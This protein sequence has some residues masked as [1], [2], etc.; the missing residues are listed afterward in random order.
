ML[1]RIEIEPEEGSANASIIWLH[2]LGASGDDFAPIVPQLKLDE[3]IYARFIFPHAP[4]RAI[5]F[6][7]GLEMPAWYDF[8]INGIERE[9]NPD[10]LLEI[11]Q[12][13]CEL[14]QLEI[15]RGVKSDRIV[16]AGFSQGGAIAYDVAFCCEKPLAGLMAMSTY[17]A[18]FS[19]LEHAIQ[20]ANFPVHIFHGTQDQV[21][22]LSLGE[23]AK[24]ALERK[25]W[26]PEYSLY[27][28]DHSVCLAQIRDISRF[29]NRVL[30]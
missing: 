6:N 17:I 30:A 13:V 12:Q 1:E 3:S 16:L 4:Q 8:T 10:H 14:I 7:G 28:M 23:K 24:L 27:S 19:V 22:P 29:L 2:G 26:H 21:V 20:S 18:D 5:T 11:R 25:G 15:D 9:I